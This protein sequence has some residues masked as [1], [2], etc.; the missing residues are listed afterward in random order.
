MSPLSESPPSFELEPW[1]REAQEG[2]A[3]SLSKALDYCQEYLLSF[4]HEEIAA[5]PDR[6]SKA[7]QLAKSALLE[8]RERLSTFDGHSDHELQ[9]WLRQILIKQAQLKVR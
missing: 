6:E 1:L 5:G 8:V 7:Q 9:S 4:A 2:S 3:D